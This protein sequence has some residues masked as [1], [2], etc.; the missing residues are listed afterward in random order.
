[1]FWVALLALFT[2][3]WLKAEYHRN[4]MTTTAIVCAILYLA[5]TVMGISQ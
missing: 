1:M 4:T 5:N 2:L 3:P